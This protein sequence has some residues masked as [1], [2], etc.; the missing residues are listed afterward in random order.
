MS[1]D[2]NFQGGKDFWGSVAQSPN[3]SQISNRDDFMR[4]QADQ[5]GNQRSDFQNQSSLL[6]SPGQPPLQDPSMSVGSEYWR[7]QKAA[8]MGEGAFP[9]ALNSAD[10]FW[11]QKANEKQESSAIRESDELRYEKSKT[12]VQAASMETF[13]KSQAESKKGVRKNVSQKP[14]TKGAKRQASGPRSNLSEKEKAAAYFDL[15]DQNLE[16]KNHHNKLEEELKKV[17]TQLNRLKESVK[18]ERNLAESLTGQDFKS[19]NIEISEV[20]RLK[21]EKSELA[22]KIREIEGAASTG[23]LGKQLASRDGPFLK[24]HSMKPK[25]I[26]QAVHYD[27]HKNKTP[28]KMMDDSTA[29]VGYDEKPQMQTVQIRDINYEGLIRELEDT[30][31]QLSRE[32]AKV[33][34]LEIKLKAYESS[35][36]NELVYKNQ[37]LIA[38]NK[39]LEYQLR[40]LLNS[41]FNKDSK[42]PK[43]QILENEINMRTSSLQDFQQKI[44][45]LEGNVAYLTQELKNMTQER[46]RFKDECLKLSVRLEEKNKYFDEFETQ[47]RSLGGTDVDAFMRALGLMKL[48]GEEPA[49]SRLDFIERTSNVPEDIPNLK[50]E[51]ERL[52]LEKGQLAAELE[53]IQNLLVLKNEME[54]EKNALH[55]SESEQL[56]MQLKSA[57]QRAEELARLADFRANRVIQLERN[58]RLNVYDDAN[59]IVATK[60]QISLAEFDGAAAEFVD[61]GTEVGT[62]E[63]IVDLWL[64]AAEFYLFA[65]EQ[66][67]KENMPYERNFVSFLTVDFFNHETQSTSLCEGL[68]PKYQIH[69][70]FKVNVDEFF[71]KTLEKDYIYI[72]AH[73]NKGD[74]HLTFARAKVPLVELLERAG[75]MSDA[76]MKPGIIESACTFVSAFDGRTSVGV[77]T[78]KL[79]MRHPLSEALRWFK[80]KQEIVE[81]SNPKQY[82]LETVYAADPNLKERSLMVTVFRC[83]GLT[84]TVYP[85]NLRPFVFYQ[86][87]T[88]PEYMTKSAVGPDPVYDETSTIKIKVGPDLKKYLDSQTVEFIVFDDNAPIREGGQDIIGTAHVPLTALLLDTA[89]E[90]TY[91]LFNLRGQEAGGISLRIA[92]RDSKADQIG[93]GTPLTEAWEREAYERIAKALS[94]RG[95]GLDSGFAIF[96]QD[97]NG[98][99]SPQEFRNTI[100]ITLRLPLSEQEIQLLINACNL[101]DGGITKTLF[102][103]KFSGLLAADRTLK[104]EEPWE[105]QVLELVRQRI[106]EKRLSIWQTFEAFDLNKDGT[107]SAAEFRQ[108]FKIMQL[109]LNDEEIERILKYFDPRRTDK[110][111]YRIFCEKL[112]PRS[113]G[114]PTQVNNNTDAALILAKVGQLITESQLTFRDAFK[115]FDENGDGQ[116]SKQEFYKVFEMMKIGLTPRE[117][118]NLWNYLPKNPSGFLLYEAFCAGFEGTP[119]NGPGQVRTTVAQVREYIQNQLRNKRA[120]IGSLFRAFD[121]NLSGTLS[122]QEFRNA[123]EHLGLNLTTYDVE[124]LVDVADANKDGSITLHEFI[125]FVQPSENM[126]SV[127]KRMMK[128]SG[129]S[130]P[131]LF[132]I[133]DA[134]KNGIITKDE[135]K[136]VLASLKIPLTP[137]EVEALWT[138]IDKDKSNTINFKEFQDLLR[139]AAPI[140][141]T[142]TRMSEGSRLPTEESKATPVPPPDPLESIVKVIASSGI[143]LFDAF[144]VFDKNNDGYI[145]RQELIKVFQDMKLNLTN[146]QIEILLRKIDK[147]GDNR[148]SFDEFKELFKSYGTEV[149]PRTQGAA[150]TQAQAARKKIRSVPELI[151]MLDDHMTKQKLTL[152]R[153][154]NQVFDQ[155]KDS[156]ISKDELMKGFNRILEHPLTES[157]TNSLVTELCPKGQTRI[158]FNNLKDVYARYSKKSETAAQDASRRQL[159]ESSESLNRSI[160]QS[161]AKTAQD[162]RV[163]SPTQTQQDFRPSPTQTA[164]DFRQPPSQ[165][166]QDF[167]Q[168]SQGFGQGQDIRSSGLNQ[169]GQ[170]ASPAQTGQD[171]RQDSMGRGMGATQ[172][173]F[174]QAPTDQRGEQNYYNR[175]NVPPGQSSTPSQYDI[176]SS[177]TPESFRTGTDLGSY[178]AQ[179]PYNQPG[180]GRTPQQTQGNLPTPGYS[181]EPTRAP[182]EAYKQIAPGYGQEPSRAPQ[183]GQ[184]IAP[185]YGQE[186][187]RAPQQG[188]QIAPSYGQDLSR[189]PQQGQQL[190]LSYGQDLSRAPQQG[191]QIAPG[192]GQDLSRGPQQGQQIVPDYSQE[193]SRAPQQGQQIA[194]SYGQDLSRASQQGQQLALSYGQ[195]IS[196]APQQGQ[197]LALSYGQDP[198]R[199]PQQGQQ[200]APSYGQDPYKQTTPSYSRESTRGPQQPQDPYKQTAPSYGSQP[201]TTKEPPRRF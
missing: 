29:I 139:E 140:S 117:I 16:L 9:Q 28:I 12:Q 147:S 119:R 190:A 58:Q 130:A 21:K 113:G 66:A 137:E 31:I 50:R 89:I 72:E 112:Q 61:N 46:D 25:V 64:G 199:A 52:K 73:I 34:E 99:I 92:W 27:I 168:S 98:L 141:R 84:G 37:E 48:K 136:R 71:I 196:R 20:E 75:P 107:V 97:Q 6:Q 194:P 82:A 155:N 159:L 129:I 59:R 165:T 133:F 86:F 188:Q 201:P 33:I 13:F 166:M 49:W 134:D 94:A 26:T 173:G 181:E 91:Q 169:P 118:E 3:A 183:Q 77:Q 157:E 74:S 68:T 70:S 192:Y 1:R 125:E 131:D 172:E 47:L 123:L 146:T 191:Q 150:Q 63:N 126:V 87:F 8:T 128:R 153:L 122:R 22:R 30:K 171:F 65:L 78:F 23:K 186:P 5:A 81:L 96:D 189:A 164:Q 182:Q 158:S 185:G 135:F 198:S 39:R 36:S 170:R 178:R 193:P 115:V 111:D 19:S 162:F 67:L 62:G 69:I 120:D 45:K 160:G 110:I 76:N 145:S 44:A 154:Y 15:Y 100:L 18:S 138:F 106:I 80:E 121:K 116:I 95:L 54:K 53:K 38:E 41:P 142:N 32:R 103:Q 51:I 200:I 148:I 144:K 101:V 35:N 151:H 156:W 79:R 93:Y 90:G 175:A 176:R 109:G 195:D 152:V 102:R 105:E 60:T 187:S 83:I 184:Q 2:L 55:S 132:N 88:E 4:S 197:Q 56:Q 124:M 174:R 180:Y 17:T 167:R 179:D 11:K 7:S 24:Q 14:G 85:G 114:K 127:F 177:N 43:L 149:N 161:Q 40:D 57:Q 143:N 10:A 42:D 108:T 104:A 163:N